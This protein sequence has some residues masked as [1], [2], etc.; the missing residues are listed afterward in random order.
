MQLCLKMEMIFMDFFKKYGLKE[1]FWSVHLLN[2]MG[3]IFPDLI[4]KVII[5]FS[6]QLRLFI[7]SAFAG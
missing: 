1:A 3:C 4:T 6:Y 7:D 5:S 2:A